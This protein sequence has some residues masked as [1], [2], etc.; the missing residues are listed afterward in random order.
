MNC[1]QCG[2]EIRSTKSVYHDHQKMCAK[3]YKQWKKIGRNLKK[4]V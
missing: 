1:K 2:R 4:Y 3:C